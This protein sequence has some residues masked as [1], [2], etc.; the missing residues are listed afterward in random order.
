MATVWIPALLRSH[1]GDQESLKVAGATLA[2]LLDAL[3]TQF[4][5]I[6]AHLVRPGIA[7]VIDGQISREGLSAAVKPDSEVHFI[8]AIGGG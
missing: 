1:A 5:G 6:K 3:E 8:P 7:V 4:P 2:E